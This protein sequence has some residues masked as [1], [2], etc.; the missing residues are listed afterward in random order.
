MGVKLQLVLGEYHI[1]PCDENIT[2]IK[3]TYL[4]IQG[5]PKL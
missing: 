2:Q 1:T 3:R 5:V 4:F